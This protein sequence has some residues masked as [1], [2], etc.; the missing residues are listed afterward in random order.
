MA[1]ST[2]LVYGTNLGGYRAA[3]ALCK[4]GYKVVLL[5][6]GSY[7]D[8]IKNQALSQL[9][10]DFCWICVH[11]PQRLFKGLGCLQDYYNAEVIEVKG[12]AGDFKVK[13]RKKDQLVNNFIR[14]ECDRCIEICPVEI[15]GKKAIY[16][17]PHVGWENIYLIDEKIC[18]KCGK[19]EEICPT[20]ALILERPEE[21]IE[22]NVG[23]IVLALEYESPSDRELVKFGLGKT[24][25]V[26]R[27]SKIAEK[28]LLTNFVQDSLRLPSGELPKKYAI[29]ITPHF[30]K[31]EVEYEN[32]NLCISAIY[33]ALKIK[34]IIPKSEVIVFLKHYKGQ[35]K[36]HYRW[37]E[38]AIER[39]VKI[40]KVE[41]LQVEE[42]KEKWW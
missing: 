21:I 28:S 1:E 31:P 25:R 22:V 36:N 35:G 42:K 6:K 37:Y 38:R 8:E 7:V 12:K 23:A 24:D 40:E 33:R 27:N 26:G 15:N 3:Y 5:N 18:T 30:N 20:G 41:N 13:F 14:T 32:Y 4:K 9:P 10:L 16:V 11:M 34:D 29:V 39:G 2:V 19:C 17:L